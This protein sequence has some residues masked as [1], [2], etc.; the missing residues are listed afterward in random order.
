M[1]DYIC[2]FYL[3][4]MIFDTFKM[5]NR[6]ISEL[7][8]VIIHIRWPFGVSNANRPINF[9]RWQNGRRKS[10]ERWIKACEPK[11]WNVFA[12]TF[13]RTPKVT[14]PMKMKRGL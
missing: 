7:F 13:S 11:F 14:E 10:T 9:L 5:H 3:F 12:V 2:R 4:L 8:Y 1:L 6:R